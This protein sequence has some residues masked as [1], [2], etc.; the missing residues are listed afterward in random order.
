MDPESG[1][2]LG[3]SAMKVMWVC[4]RRGLSRMAGYITLLCS[5]EGGHRAY[6]E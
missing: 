2:F 4:D 1:C 3:G 5:R 6:C